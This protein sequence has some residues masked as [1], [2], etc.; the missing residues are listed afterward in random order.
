MTQP[1][2][3]I[4]RITQSINFKKCGQNLFL[5]NWKLKCRFFFPWDVLSFVTFCT[6]GRFVLGTFCPWDVLSLGMFCPWDLMSEDVQSWDVLSLGTVCL[7]TFCLCTV[8]KSLPSPVDKLHQEFPGLVNSGNGSPH[9]K[10]GCSTSLRRRAALCLPGPAA[11]IPTSSR[12]SRKSWQV[13]TS[14]YYKP[15]LVGR[16]PASDG[17]TNFSR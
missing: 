10:H 16:L 17:F 14:R 2:L 1:N 5:K 12:L 7:G 4:I 11:W 3:P 13:G 9:P 8:M 15:V 6:L